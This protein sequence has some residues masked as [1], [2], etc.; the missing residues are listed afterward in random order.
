VSVTDAL[1]DTGTGT[2]S[3]A[4]VD[5]APVAADDV[6]SLD[7]DAG[8]VSGNVVSDAD[9]ASDDVL[10]ADATSSPVTGVVAGTGVPSGNVGS[11]VVGSYGT[12]TINADG[13]YT[14]VID[15]A[16]TVVQGLQSG[17]TLS[18]VFSYEITDADG[19]TA[20]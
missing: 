16:N 6:A 3:V 8:S 18:E 13:S 11:G 14:Y 12:V 4:I 7:E 1:G 17:E 15:P 10:G 9:P 20:T 19:D 2:L 5:D